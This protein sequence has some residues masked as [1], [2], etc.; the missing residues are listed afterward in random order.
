MDFGA[1]YDGTGML[2]VCAR[3]HAVCFFKCPCKGFLRGKSII[4][5]D[6]QKLPLAVPDLFQREGQPS[7]PEIAA[8]RQAGYFMEFPG[9]MKFRI[10]QPAGKS[11]QGQGFFCNSEIHGGPLSFASF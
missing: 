7:L 8:Q 9:G 6:I 3:C 5:G 4:K 11:A 10:S 1:E 2:P